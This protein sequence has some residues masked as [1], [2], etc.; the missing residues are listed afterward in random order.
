MSHGAAPALIALQR[1][2]FFFFAFLPN[3]SMLASQTRRCGHCLC[4]SQR[5]LAF[6]LAFRPMP[7][8]WLL[9][10]HAPY[11]VLPSQCLL[12]SVLTH[13]SAFIP[14]FCL[15]QLSWPAP[16]RGRIA[17][18][19]TSCECFPDPEL[20]ILAPC[21][22]CTLAGG[23]LASVLSTGCGVNNYVAYFLC[24]E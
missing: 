20:F 9:R 21:W 13:L 24:C 4:D 12:S 23:V 19:G 18:V 3:G 17:T 7:P 1:T 16:F 8:R 6:S 10:P 22:V 2:F 5:C 11:V 14:S 15:S